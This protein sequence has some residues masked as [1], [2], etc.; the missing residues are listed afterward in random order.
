MF[1]TSSGHQTRSPAPDSGP[2]HTSPTTC[3]TT[4][5]ILHKRRTRRSVVISD[6]PTRPKG[7]NVCKKMCI[8]SQTRKHDVKDT[9]PR[10][11][12]RKHKI[13]TMT[14]R[15]LLHDYK[16]IDFVD[17]LRRARTNQGS[18]LPK[19]RNPKCSE[20]LT[21]PKK[22]NENQGEGHVRTFQKCEHTKKLFSL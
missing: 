8:F 17:S 1:L 20:P 13:N 5:I 18:W 6:N 12:S 7:C 4:H 14:F 3:F 10:M 11:S 21:S 22:Q 9:L 16:Q 2:K 19:R 15:K